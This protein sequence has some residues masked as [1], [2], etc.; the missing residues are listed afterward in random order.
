MPFT[1]ISN[2][3]LPTLDKTKLPTGSVVQ[4]KQNSLNLLSTTST[5]YASMG[6]VSITPTSASNKIFIMY[7]THEF[8][9]QLA[10][11]TWRGCLT[12]LLRDST[13]ILTDGTGAVYGNGAYFTNDADRTMSYT[14]H[15]FLDS[16]NTT[17]AIS[18]QVD[19]RSKYNAHQ[20][21]FNQSS[22]GMGG[23]ITAMEIQA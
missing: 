5:S 15:N 13:E 14:S 18:Y 8:I 20:V 1:T 17:N 12:R 3:V 2:T 22:Y 21:Q 23:R 16:P 11:N 6:S 19:G 7:E 4:V 10:T 9:N